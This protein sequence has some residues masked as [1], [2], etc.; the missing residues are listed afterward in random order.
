MS[1]DDSL[2]LLAGAVSGFG[3][4]FEC[5]VFRVQSLGLR[6]TDSLRQLAGAVSVGVNEG[7]KVRAARSICI[8]HHLAARL[9]VSTERMT[10]SCR[11]PSAGTCP[12]PHVD[13]EWQERPLG[14]QKRDLL[15][16]KRPTRAR[17][18]QQ[19]DAYLRYFSSAT[20]RSSTKAG[21]RLPAPIFFAGIFP[22]NCGNLFA[23]L[24]VGG[25]RGRGE[26]GER[27]GRGEGRSRR[28]A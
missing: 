24:G 11:P 8:L 3:L 28:G 17:L 26:E 10:S 25:G 18:Q 7:A 20:R 22:A 19:K 2:R 27:G 4:I 5:L 9:C 1:T 6:R 13:A 16:Q 15:A 21:L 14:C 23:G 12:R